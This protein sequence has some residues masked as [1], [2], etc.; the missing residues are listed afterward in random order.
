MRDYRPGGK[1]RT[2]DHRMDWVDVRTGVTRCN[3]VCILRRAI[4]FDSA[5][6]LTGGTNGTNVFSN[7]VIGTI[8]YPDKSTGQP[9]TVG[10]EQQR[11]TYDGQLTLQYQ[12]HSGAANTSS[13]PSTQ[14]IYTAAPSH[15]GAVVVGETDSTSSLAEEVGFEPTVETSPTPAFKTGPFSRSGTPPAPRVDSICP[16]GTGQ[17]RSARATQGDA[18]LPFRGGCGCGCDVWGRAD[19]FAQEN[20]RE[21]SSTQNTA[22]LS[23]NMTKLSQNCPSLPSFV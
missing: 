3:R 21:T 13:T 8:E 9:G 12:S 10:G 17:K 7:D 5:K 2:V 23:S 1:S 18:T 6:Q 4:G 22:S 11:F 16:G 20:A 19:R 15:A 14:Y